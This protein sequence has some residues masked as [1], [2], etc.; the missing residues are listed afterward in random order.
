MLRGAIER[1]SEE[2]ICGWLWCSDAALRGKTVLAF[3]DDE[4]LGAGSIDLFRQDILDAGLGDGYAG[5]HFDLTYP[6][7]DEA[8]RVVVK[9][10]CSDLVL[11]QQ[12]ARVAAP[13]RPSRAR[14]L[15]RAA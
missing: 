2:G 5:F 9:L 4:C 6:G 3:L 8:R 14:E 12:G 1:V 7:P 10:E 13:A 15:H 11:M